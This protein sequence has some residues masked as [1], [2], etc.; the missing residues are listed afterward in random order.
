MSR[1]V[2]EK[3]GTLQITGDMVDLA[4]DFDPDQAVRYLQALT[5]S[6]SF[7][8]YL[9]E[10]FDEELRITPQHDEAAQKVLRRR[11]MKLLKERAQAMGVAEPAIHRWLNGS[12]DLHSGKSDWVQEL[13]FDPT[14]ENLYQLCGLLGFDREKT[15]S[16]FRRA[17]FYAPWNRKSWRELVY[18]FF[19]SQDP[20]HWYAESARLIGEIE[21]QMQERPDPSHGQTEADVLLETC[22]IDQQLQ[23]LLSGRVTQ[24][25]KEAFR[26]F[27]L[28]HRDTFRPEHLRYTASQEILALFEASQ[29]YVLGEVQ[30]ALRLGR[31]D[32]KRGED[33]LSGEPSANTVFTVLLEGVLPEEDASPIAAVGPLPRPLRLRRR[34]LCKDMVKI[35]RRLLEAEAESREEAVSDTRLRKLLLLLNFYYFY[36]QCRQMRCGRANR[37]CPEAGY[38]LLADQEEDYS[39]CFQEF[40]DVTNRSLRETGFCALYEGNGLDCLFL[41]AAHTRQPLRALRAIVRQG[42]GGM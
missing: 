41:L 11:Q 38:Q 28:D 7:F 39:D 3:L 37:Q 8:W 10:C 19:I 20:E 5:Q 34:E 26:A 36:A 35:H 15:E 32:G 17:A 14:R 13:G 33:L 24:Q 29:P 4:L 27:L 12:I 18:L 16:F 2:Q 9:Q 1:S 30:S 25:T 42:A 6:N 40:C 21:P 22:E 31:M 23:A